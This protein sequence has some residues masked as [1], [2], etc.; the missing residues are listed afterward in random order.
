MARV[1]PSSLQ[2][3]LRACAC[4]GWCAALL[5]SPA[6]ARGD[7]TDELTNVFLSPALSQWLVGAIGRIASSQEVEEYLAIDVDADAEAFI[8]RFW[9]ARDDDPELPGNATRSLFE[10]RQKEADDEYTESA[11]PGRRTA[12]GIIY[13]IY[14]APSEIDYE[15]PKIKGGESVVKWLYPKDA[16]PGIDGKKPLRAYRFV[17][18]GDLTVFYDASMD[19]KARARRLPVRP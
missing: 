17:R 3:I 9:A 14:G 6:S 1:P 10:L 7:R 5:V 4:V 12:R 19:R 13:T 15:V 18:Q 2:K 8:E 11:Y 16:A